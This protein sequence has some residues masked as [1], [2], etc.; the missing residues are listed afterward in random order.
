M[1]YPNETA[2]ITAANFESLYTLLTRTEP[3]LEERTFRQETRQAMNEEA[4]RQHER[5]RDVQR[6][7]EERR[8]MQRAQEMTRIIQMPLFQP[9][10]GTAANNTAIF[11]QLNAQS[12]WTLAGRGVPLEPTPK[13]VPVK[14]TFR[15][16][17][18][19]KGKID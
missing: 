8:N 4:Q 11:N 14:R 12:G 9:Y 2:A 6:L 1:A 17:L 10:E 13:A 16:F 3:S 7:N 18:K 5:Y 15:Q 19:E